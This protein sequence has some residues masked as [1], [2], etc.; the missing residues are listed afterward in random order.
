MR[1]IFIYPSPTGTDN[2][3]I[4]QPE[5]RRHLFLHQMGQ[6]KERHLH[7][8]LFFRKCNNEILR[9][10]SLN[11]LYRF[12][13]FCIEFVLAAVAT[14]ISSLLDAADQIPR[15]HHPEVAAPAMWA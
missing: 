8:Q 15:L 7:L 13:D 2:Q 11:N 4:Q 6:A 3:N 1:A 5:Y 9:I 12:G 10:R 14:S